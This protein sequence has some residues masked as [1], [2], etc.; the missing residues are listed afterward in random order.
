[1]DSARRDDVRERAG[2]QCEYCRL[3]QSAQPW[4]RFH[5]EHVIPRQHGGSDEADNLC[6][7]C[8]HCN[9]HKGPNVASIDAVT[10]R[11]TRLFDPRRDK[12]TDHF[13]FASNLVVGRTEEGRVTVALLKMNAPNRVQLR[14]ELAS[15][16][17]EADGGV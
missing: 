16:A 10:Q 5:I 7:A 1:M 12:W 14:V 6:L 8:G 17:R 15:E 9:R 4:A 11:L 13:E 3:P 2:H